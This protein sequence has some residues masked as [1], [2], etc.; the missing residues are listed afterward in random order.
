MSLKNRLHIFLFVIANS[1][2]KIF[3]A[4]YPQYFSYNNENGLPSN[5]VYSIVQ[6]SKGFIWIGCDAGLFKF[7]GIRYIPYKCQTQNSNSITGLSFSNSKK[8]YCYNF[9]SQIFYLDNDSLHELK[10]DFFKINSL[11]CDK[12]NNVYVAHTKGISQYNETSQKWTHYT[13]K[14]TEGN[15]MVSSVN[16]NTKNQVHFLSSEGI[17][18]LKNGKTNINPSNLFNPAGMYL[19]RNVNDKQFILSTYNDIVYEVKNNNVTKLNNSLYQNLQNKK[20]TNAVLLPDSNLWVCT[21]K[22]LICYNPKTQQAD[23][24]YPEISFSDVLIDQEGNY[25]FSTLQTGL[26]RVPDFNFIVW[27]KENELLKNDKITKLASD[28]TFIYFSTINGIIGRLNPVTKELKTFHTGNNADAQSLDYDFAEQRLYFNINK[29]LFFIQ[30]SK[31]EEKN[32]DISTLKS[33][34]KI[35][36]VYFILSAYGVHIYG[37]ENYKI[38]DSWSR[39][40][41]YNYKNN[42]VWIA[43]NSGLLKAEYQNGK[44]QLSETFLKHTQILSLD[45]DETTNRIFALTFNGKIYSITDEKKL[46]DISTVPKEVQAKKLKYNTGKLFVASN[47]GLWICDMKKLLWKNLNSL[48]GL[49]SENVQDLVIQSNSIWLATGKGL[50]KIPIEEQAEKTLAKIYLKNPNT[51]NNKI[52]LDYQEPFILY[53]E[54]SIYAANGNFKYAYRINQNEWI[55]L[56]ATIE[57]IE[58][59]NLPPGK[60]AVELKVIDNKGRDSEN[61]ITIA[62]FVQPPFWQKWWFISLI[63]LLIAAIVFIVVQK[64]IATIKKREHEK[65]ELL[66]SQLKAIGAQMNPHFMYNT[67][68]SIQDLI[69]QQDIK[70]TNHYLSRFSQ[71]M[72]QILAFSEEDKVLLCEEKEM[73]QN[74]LEL[75]K[76]RFGNDF[77]YTISIDETIDINRTYIPGLIVQ[78][79]VENAVKHG[80]LH[81][82]GEKKLAVRF[83]YRSNF[84][85]I[86]IEDN[87]IGRKRSAEIKQRNSFT[88]KSFANEAVQKRA[89]LLNTSGKFRITI[90]TDD[91][92]KNEENTGTKIMITILL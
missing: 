38:S 10:T 70:N 33:I 34:R 69:L 18:E 23:L 5:E 30:N 73:L 15:P 74:Y 59:Q 57:Q 60:F 6:D 76:L 27:N 67:L 58:I 20:V 35:N 42:T 13:T 72:R 39:E 28:S 54:A 37:K 82:K 81:K 14:E 36:D 50:Q 4:Q 1:I 17:C 29:H 9:Q 21:Y 90:Q 56:P 86:V 64:I 89:D 11:A 92:F 80:L 7:D 53:P 22:G 40:L 44:W 65:N 24:F 63:I 84:L 32:N 79:Y 52:Q 12:N 45:F 78:P 51:S 19:L 68:N 8:L 25:W 16:I 66:S 26:M 47:K 61:V 85:E 31:I 43:S 88:H 62:G 46:I 71:L 87:G 41:I 2:A 3:F 49:A 77:S 91:V 75:E 83:S 55:T 48:S